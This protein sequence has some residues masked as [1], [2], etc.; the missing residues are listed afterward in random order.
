MTHHPV[1]QPITVNFTVTD[2]SR[3]RPPYAGRFRLD[4]TQQ[5]RAFAERCNAAIADGFV[6]TASCESAVRE[7]RAAVEAATA[8]KRRLGLVA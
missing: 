3:R 1:F 2:P 5:R 8:I 4:D 7:R 6:V